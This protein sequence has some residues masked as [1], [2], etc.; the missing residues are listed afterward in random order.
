VAW[1]VLLP[2]PGTCE[3]RGFMNRLPLIALVTAALAAGCS[4]DPKPPPR[5]ASSQQIG[6]DTVPRS[7]SARPPARQDTTSPTSGSVHVDE[8][9]LAAC[10]DIPIAHFAFDSARIQPDAGAVLDAIARCFVSGPLKGHGMKL[11]GHADP[12]GEHEYNFGL[13]QK[14]AGSVGSYLSGRSLEA[15]R[16]Q[17]SSKGD[18]D[19]SGIDEAGWA[20]DR[21]VDILLDD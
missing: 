17:T 15:S 2:D 3:H 9:I 18:S 19:A 4:S 6:S 5:F 1:A 21:K 20:R 12:R 16:M 7:A 13:G 14:R 10:G 8:K 11:I